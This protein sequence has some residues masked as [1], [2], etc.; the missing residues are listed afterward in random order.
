MIPTSQ[1]N[2]DQ[3]SSIEQLLAFYGA[4][5]YLSNN[6]LYK[7]YL[8]CPKLANHVVLKSNNLAT[9]LAS[10]QDH[11]RECASCHSILFEEDYP[12]R[13][14]QFSQ[15]DTSLLVLLVPPNLIIYVDG[16]LLLQAER[17]ILECIL[18]VYL[19]AEEKKFYRSAHFNME[20]VREWIGETPA[21]KMSVDV[22]PT[23][24]FA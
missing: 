15:P 18:G 8:L 12:H 1:L 20:T 2:S 4:N 3:D 13:H 23:V 6:K 10:F 22:P 21:T 19:N 11:L 16:N 5:E 17:V 9:F 14:H 7:V 24:D